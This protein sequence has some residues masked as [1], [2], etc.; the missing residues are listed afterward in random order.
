V[1]LIQ[2]QNPTWEDLVAEWERTAD[3]SLRSG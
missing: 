1:A 2:A 3:P